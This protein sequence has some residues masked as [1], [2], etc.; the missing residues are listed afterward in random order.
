MGQVKSLLCNVLR[1][2][3]NAME[4]GTSGGGGGRR[5]SRG[6]GV[7]GTS[8]ISGDAGKAG[9]RSQYP[10]REPGGNFIKRW[11]RRVTIT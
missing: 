3:K 8:D 7:G 6:D 2:M 10:H 11:K 9:S 1:D 4:K 5:N